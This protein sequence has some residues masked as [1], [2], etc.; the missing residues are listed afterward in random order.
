[1]LSVILCDSLKET[2]KDKWM[3]GSFDWEFEALIG[4]LNG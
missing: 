1:M 4:V 3:F 2:L